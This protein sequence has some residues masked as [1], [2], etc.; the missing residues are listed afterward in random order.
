M[1]RAPLVSKPDTRYTGGRPSAQ[2]YYRKV[3]EICDY[4]TE[5]HCEN[6]GL[7][8][9]IRISRIR[10]AQESWCTVE[11]ACNNSFLLAALSI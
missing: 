8:K 6:G 5:A 2:H 10:T 9:S 1:G 3:K 11:S 7:A 4:F